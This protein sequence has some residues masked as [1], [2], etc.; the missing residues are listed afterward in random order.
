VYMQLD[1]RLGAGQLESALETAMAG[2]RVL[3]DYMSA[4]IRETMME[5]APEI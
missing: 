3:R 1:A 5:Q 2:C 4:A